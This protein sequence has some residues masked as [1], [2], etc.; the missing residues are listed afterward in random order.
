MAS[1]IS[2]HKCFKML[3]N[4]QE[5]YQESATAMQSDHSLAPAVSA[6]PV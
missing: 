1:G 4:T 5:K 3:I 2:S 6:K